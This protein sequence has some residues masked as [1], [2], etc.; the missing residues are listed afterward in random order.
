MPK[1]HS[2]YIRIEISEVVKTPGDKSRRE[3]LYNLHTEE[4]QARADAL[5]WMNTQN[6]IRSFGEDIADAM[7]VT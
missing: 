5:Q 3:S 1:L 4:F 2:P 6:N 7:D